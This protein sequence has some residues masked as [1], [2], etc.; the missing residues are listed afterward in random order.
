M[1]RDRSLISAKTC[2]SWE[3]RP[4]APPQ[5]FDLTLASCIAGAAQSQSSLVFHFSDCLSSTLPDLSRWQKGY[6]E[7]TWEPPVQQHGFEMGFGISPSSSSATRYYFGLLQKIDRLALR[8]ATDCNYPQHLPI[9]TRL[10]LKRLRFLHLLILTAGLIQR[11]GRTRLGRGYRWRFISAVCR[12]ISLLCKVNQAS[13]F[14]SAW[15]YF[16]TS[17]L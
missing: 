8:L 2:S 3:W 15:N 1:A 10:G 13:S 4:A 9:L 12:Q 6:C 11:C 16:A 5:S 14:R 7:V 17:L